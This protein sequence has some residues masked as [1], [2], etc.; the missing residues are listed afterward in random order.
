MPI[1]SGI[2][3][4]LQSL[5]WDHVFV[6]VM[7]G[8]DYHIST[9]S[10]WSTRVL[11]QLGL[12]SILSVSFLPSELSVGKWVYKDMHCNRALFQSKVCIVMLNPAC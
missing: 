7:S 5:D 12:H 8:E 4:L 11:Q 2:L 9:R 3:C 6:Y 10:P 1:I